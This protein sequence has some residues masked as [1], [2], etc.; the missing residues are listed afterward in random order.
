MLRLTRRG[1]GEKECMRFL[2]GSVEFGP[3]MSDPPRVIGPAR[4]IGPQHITGLPLQLDLS[5]YPILTSLS[6]YP[7]HLVKMCYRTILHDVQEMLSD[8]PLSDPRFFFFVLASA[9]R[10][11]MI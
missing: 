3:T 1:K 7:H 10:Y 6:D 9:Q 5:D 4:V 2:V 8:Y 11:H